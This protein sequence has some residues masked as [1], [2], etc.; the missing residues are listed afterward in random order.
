VDEDPELPVEVPLGHGDGLERLPVGAIGAGSDHAVGL[1]EDLAAGTVE[2]VGVKS[3]GEEA[4]GEGEPE[5]G[6]RAGRGERRHG[7]LG[8][9]KT[10]DAPS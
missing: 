2:V 7:Y 3:R 10:G 8:G 5:A 1:G 4:Q 9:E 6:E